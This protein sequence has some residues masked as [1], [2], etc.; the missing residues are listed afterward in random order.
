MKSKNNLSNLNV[1]GVNPKNATSNKSENGNIKFD[2]KVNAHSNQKEIDWKGFLDWSSNYNDGT[3]K[4]KVTPEDAK[5]FEHAMKAMINNEI[6]DLKNAVVIVDKF[7]DLEKDP[8]LKDEIIN[9]L[10]II[11]DIVERGIEQ[12]RDLIRIGMHQPLIQA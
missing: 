11:F 4:S 8:L 5:W 3:L 7:R 6:D 1:Q 9:A 12:S 2:G 10:E